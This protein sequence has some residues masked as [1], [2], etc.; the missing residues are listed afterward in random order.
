M[1]SDPISKSFGVFDIYS[2][3][4]V[5][6]AMFHCHPRKTSFSFLAMKNRQSEILTR[7]EVCSMNS[8]PQNIR[9][10][11]SVQHFSN[12]SRGSLAMIFGHHTIETI[13][14]S[15]N[16]KNLHFFYF[17]CFLVT[18][19]GR[20][21]WRNDSKLSQNKLFTMKFHEFIFSNQ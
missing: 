18:F 6:C 8:G 5:D 14:N 7:N 13:S 9:C 10:Q 15:Q 16:S 20:E 12:G 19:L 4:A 17:S 2:S 1:T 3:R 21:T 11:K